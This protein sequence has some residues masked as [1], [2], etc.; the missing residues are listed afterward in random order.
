MDVDDLARDFGGDVSFWGGLDV[1]V[2]VPR[3]TPEDIDREV[4]HLVEVLGGPRG[5]YLGGTS[6]TILPDAPLEN[7][8]AAFDAFERHCGA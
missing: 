5:G 4:K 7:I 1:Q 6:H 3:G 2:T 8:R